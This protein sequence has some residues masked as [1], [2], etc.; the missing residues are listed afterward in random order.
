M[1]TTRPERLRKGCA[2]QKWPMWMMVRSGAELVYFG[3]IWGS[4]EVTLG[5]VSRMEVREGM[6]WFPVKLVSQ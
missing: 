3:A 5:S 2:D 1:V 6:I 4:D